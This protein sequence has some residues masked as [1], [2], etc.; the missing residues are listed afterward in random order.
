MDALDVTGRSPVGAWRRDPVVALLPG[1]RDDAY[2]N[3][4]AL[5]D[6][7]E[8]LS[9]ALAPSRQGLVGLVPLAPGLDRERALAVLAERGWTRQVPAGPSP[10]APAGGH[11]SAGTITVEKG[12]ARLRIAWGMFGD[13]LLAADLVI[14]L[15]GTANEQAAGL[16]KPVVVFPGPGIQFNPRF[17]KAQKRLLGDAVAV[18]P[19]DPAAVAAE[20]AAILADDARRQRMGAGRPGAHG[21]PGPRTGWPRS[22][23]AFGTPAPPIH[24]LREGRRCTRPFSAEP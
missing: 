4:G 21:P 1:S 17:L 11:D 3:L 19:P 2:I 12:A 18:A 10:A 8:Q 20:A 7:L 6:C 5:A 9:R 16:G 23:C 13:V 14:G 24:D 15:A 22:S